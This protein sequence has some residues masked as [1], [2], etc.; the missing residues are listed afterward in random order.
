MNKSAIVES[1]K[2]QRSS[3]RDST[4]IVIHGM[5]ES[6]NDEKNVHD[7]SKDTT[8]E[9]SIARVYRISK[10]LGDANGYQAGANHIRSVRVELRSMSDRKDVLKRP[11]ALAQSF[12]NGKIYI[13]KCLSANELEKIKKM[14]TQC[15]ELNKCA[16]CPNGRNQF[17][18]I[19]SKIMKRHDNGKF[20]HYTVNNAESVNMSQTG[21]KQPS[22]NRLS[23]GDQGSGEASVVT[24]NTGTLNDQNSQ[25]SSSL[26]SLKNAV[27]EG[28]VA[29]VTQ[30]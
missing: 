18:F 1:I 27:G 24:T 13:T 20:A 2:E 14:H 30:P 8:R 9:G 22:P 21:S 10:R 16:K 3:E 25:N 6:K 29:P 7:L 5:L 26:A 12:K 4:S 28:H 17:L 19:D 11:K 23:A 15:L